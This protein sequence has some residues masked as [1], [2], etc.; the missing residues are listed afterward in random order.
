MPL[1]NVDEEE[2]ELFGEMYLTDNQKA[3]EEVEDE[4]MEKKE[5]MMSKE[6]TR[7]KTLFEENGYVVVA[8]DFVSHEMA[9]MFTQYALFEMVNS[10]EPNRD[11][12]VPGAYSNYANN[13]AETLLIGLKGEV[14]GHTGKTLIPTYSYYRVYKAGDV[15]EDHKDRPACEISA[16]IMMGYRHAPNSEDGTEIDGIDMYNWALHGYVNGEKKYFPHSASGAVIYKGCE[17]EHGRDKFNVGEYSYQ[18]QLFLHYVDADGPYAKEWAFDK[19][20]SVG[21]KKETIARVY[22]NDTTDC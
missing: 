22:G 9:D 16:T 5:E 3:F 12:Q 15:L 21:L 10:E 1:D 19:R 20:P 4:Y 11:E 2:E 13:L 14:E 7:N 18:V 6:Y 17:L 8:R